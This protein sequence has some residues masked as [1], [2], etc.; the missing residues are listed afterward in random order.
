MFLGAVGEFG[1]FSSE[2]AAVSSAAD[3]VDHVVERADVTGVCSG[4][5][6]NREQPV[7]L[8]DIRDADC[9]RIS[10]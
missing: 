4:G 8:S 2:K 10:W 5:M 1:T 9:W 7:A 6:G 3:V